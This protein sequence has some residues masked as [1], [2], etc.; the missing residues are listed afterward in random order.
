MTAELEVVELECIR[1]NRHLFSKLN[2]SLH[3]GQLQHLVGAN[4]SGKTSLLR[5]LSGLSLP[6]SGKILWRGL[7]VEGAWESYYQNLT[8]IGH[9]NGIKA[10]L[11]PFEN[12]Q[13]YSLLGSGETSKNIE[14]ALDQAGLGAF[15]DQP[16]RTLSMGQCRRVALARLFL[17]QARLW[18]LD[19][20]VTGIDESGVK[21]FEQLFE[22][23]IDNGGIILLTSHRLLCKNVTKFPTIQIGR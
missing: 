4:G 15:R 8:Y 1:E 19:E 17:S 14:S 20:P 23:H 3:S 9:A 18:L 2:F 22:R 5:I 12:I 21:E 11:T 6:E 10:E 7:R 13:I 16:C